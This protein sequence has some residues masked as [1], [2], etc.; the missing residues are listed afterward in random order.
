MLRNDNIDNAVKYWHDHYLD[1]FDYVLLLPGTDETL[2]KRINE[3]F[4]AKLS[5]RNGIVIY[6]E[7]A[8]ELK[9]LY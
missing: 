7:A 5:G 4:L 8:R 9:S 1:D 6:N 2:N 3:A